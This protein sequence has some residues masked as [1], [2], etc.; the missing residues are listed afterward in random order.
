MWAKPAPQWEEADGAGQMWRD[1]REGDPTLHLTFISSQITWVWLSLGFAQR[2]APQV[3]DDNADMHCWR[4]TGF[5]RGPRASSQ[6]RQVLPY[7]MSDMRTDGA[8]HAL[9]SARPD[10]HKETYL[11]IGSGAVRAGRFT[12]FV[13]KMTSSCSPKQEFTF[14]VWLML[15][16]RTICAAWVLESLARGHLSKKNTQWL[17]HLWPFEC[18][19]ISEN[20]QATLPG[21]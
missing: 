15:S 21:S 9:P 7:M 20:Q 10:G 19:I 12:R 16:Y 11:R 13:Q 14:L 18:G 5:W 4:V 17:K 1:L 2:G 3:L 8:K 6:L